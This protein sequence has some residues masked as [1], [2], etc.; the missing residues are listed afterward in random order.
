MDRF[1]QGH[2]YPKLEVLRLT[3]LGLAGNQIRASVVGSE[4]SSKELFKQRIIANRN[5]YI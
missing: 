4:H 3:C 1:D 5:I 2:L